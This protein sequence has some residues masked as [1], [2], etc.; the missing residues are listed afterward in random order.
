MTYGFLL[1]INVYDFVVLLWQDLESY[2]Y[3]E[4]ENIIIWFYACVYCVL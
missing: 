2:Y 3:L 1:V 4:L